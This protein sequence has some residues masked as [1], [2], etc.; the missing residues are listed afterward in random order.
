M[1]KY[2]DI[3]KLLSFINVKTKELEEAA[4]KLAM[5]TEEISE[6]GVVNG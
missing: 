1:E 5:L 3:F 4:N 2:N 6:E